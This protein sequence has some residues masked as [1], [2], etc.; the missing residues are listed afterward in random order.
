MNNS[1]YL[2]KPLFPLA[3]ALPRMLERIEGELAAALP[4]EQECLL[5]RA[6]LIRGLLG[7]AALAGQQQAR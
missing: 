5:E 1:P 3:V 7:V 2:D 4:A 6:E